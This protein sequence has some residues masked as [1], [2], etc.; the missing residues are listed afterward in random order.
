MISAHPATPEPPS[1][2]YYDGVLRPND[3][4]KVFDHACTC[5]EPGLAQAVQLDRSSGRRLLPSE[6]GSRFGLGA[7]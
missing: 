1:T 3:P 4:F 5:G 6:A 7:A 2:S